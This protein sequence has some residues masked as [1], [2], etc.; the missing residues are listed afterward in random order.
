M[1]DRSMAHIEKVKAIF[2]IEGADKI[3]LISILD[4]KIIVK[5]NQFKVGDLAVFIEVDSIVP[6]GI[7][8]ENKEKLN[9]LYENL[10]TEINIEKKE[11]IQKE[12][13]D[14]VNTYSKWPQFE[15][16]RKK[17][18]KI[19]AIK[20]SKFGNIISQG[21]VF[22]LSEFPIIVNP[23]VGMD[24]TKLLEIEHEIEDEEEAGINVPFHNPI[25]KFIDKKMMRFSFYRNWKKEKS[26]NQNGWLS[27]FPTRSDEENAQKVFSKLYEK[28]G[29]EPWV[30]SE[31]LEGQ[32]I[33]IWSK[34]KKTI[35]G[36]TKKE[37]SVCTHTR[38]LP[39][40]KESSSQFW[41]TVKALGYDKIIASIPGNWF[42]RG[43]HLGPGIQNN[44]YQLTRNEI[45][46]FDFYELLPDKTFRKLS[47][48]ESIAFS[49]KWNLPFVPIIDDNF[50][51]P[52]NID[53]LLSYSDGITVFG[54]Q[55]K[56]IREG[57]VIRLKSNY[58]I[59]FKAKSPKYHIWWNGKKK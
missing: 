23:K 31:K 40:A 59:S 3:E 16:L 47:Y 35:F 42:C 22:S 45:R 14:F 46:F 49:R 9:Q 56:Q 44:I 15:F 19:K 30:V 4:W 55:P 2:P 13:D 5:K 53:D 18:F 7:S 41:K 51:L 34:D 25:T 32:N 54:N 33:T 21:I 58:D 28:Y 48:N 17:K 26:K 10:K 38:N 24:V 6:D 29:G 1:Y 20:Y 27:F 11:S 50:I 37:V 43:E 8:L 57:V 36:K 52:S 12:I 39:Y